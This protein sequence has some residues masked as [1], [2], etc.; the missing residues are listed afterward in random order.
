M[1]AGNGEPVLSPRRDGKAYIC[2]QMSDVVTVFVAR[3]GEAIKIN[4]LHELDIRNALRL[5]GASCSR[6]HCK[7][8]S[9][10][11]KITDTWP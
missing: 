6:R 7:P 2:E 10:T 1:V 4:G 3:R 8:A 5:S 11:D 9:R